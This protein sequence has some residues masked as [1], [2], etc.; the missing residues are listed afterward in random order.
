MIQEFTSSDFLSA[1]DFRMFTCKEN[2]HRVFV[3]LSFIALIGEG[4]NGEA[5]LIL[6]DATKPE[7]AMALKESFDEAVDIVNGKIEDVTIHRPD[8]LR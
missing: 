5:L 1:N 2:N 3:P 6:R 8:P 4:N 7:D